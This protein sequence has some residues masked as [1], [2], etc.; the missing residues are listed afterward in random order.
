MDED[1]IVG[2]R[3]VAHNLWCHDDQSG[4]ADSH[5]VPP[6]EVVAHASSGL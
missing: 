4:I 5:F 6:M 1:E 3:V 2:M